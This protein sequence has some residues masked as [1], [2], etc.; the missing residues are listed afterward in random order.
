MFALKSCQLGLSAARDASVLAAIVSPR[1]DLT[2]GIAY[3]IG[4]G[5][6]SGTALVLAAPVARAKRSLF[7]SGAGPVGM[8]SHNL[9]PRRV[10][11]IL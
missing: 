1:R 6:A 5:C 8:S 11:V 4:P 2:A 7:C 10:M 9:A 3:S